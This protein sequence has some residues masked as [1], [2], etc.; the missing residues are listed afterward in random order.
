MHTHMYKHKYIV[1]T[2]KYTH[3]FLQSTD[4]L[5]TLCWQI[6]HS[7]THHELRNEALQTSR[8]LGSQTMFQFEYIGRV[9]R[10]G[11]LMLIR[12]RSRGLKPLPGFSV[13]S[14]RSL[15]CLRRRPAQQ[16]CQAV[17][18]ELSLVN[19][20]AVRVF[21]RRSNDAF[22]SCPRHHPQRVN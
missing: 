10:H 14:I 19:S 7:H 9:K 2:H 4:V 13:F 20:F 22:S 5:N 3:V 18:W 8:G 6:T 1:Y 21:V 15:V 11:C 17:A 16:G 12:R